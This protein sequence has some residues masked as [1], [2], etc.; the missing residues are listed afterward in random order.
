MRNLLIMLFFCCSL[1]I[2]GAIYY[3]SPS[4]SD[5]NPGTIGQPFFTLNKAWSVVSAGDIIYMRGGTYRYNNTGSSLTGKS[6]TS[7]NL[8]SILAYPGEKPIINYNN[9]TFTS[10][11]IGINISDVSYLY[12]KGI[13]VTGIKQP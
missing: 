6:G 13:R 1:T 11:L 3:V 8:I 5:S 12:M 2:S 10:Q 4:G 9:E 7:G